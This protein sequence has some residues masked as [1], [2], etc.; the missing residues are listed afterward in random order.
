MNTTVAVPPA[1]LV[2]DQF[3]NPVSGHDV[4]FAVTAGGGTV[5]PATAIA[6]DGNGIARVTAWTLGTTAGMANNTLTATAAG[7]GLTGNPVTFTASAVADVAANIA[8]MAGDS[9][10]AVSETA[11]PTDPAVRVT[12]QFGNDVAGE[13]VTFQVTGGGGAV[14]GGTPTTN[15]SGVAAVGSWSVRATGPGDDLG[16]TGNTLEASI[17]AGASVTFTGFGVFSYETHVHPKWDQGC[18]GCHGGVAGLEL[19]PDAATSYAALVGVNPVCDTDGSLVPQGY[20][21]IATGGGTAARDLSI[22]WTFIAPPT[23]LVGDCDAQYMPNA[24]GMSTG[25]RDTIQAWI[26]NGAPDN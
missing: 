6:T 5:D 1:V 25:A 19:N 20:R 2:T 12:D 9:L 4:T 23:P 8:I 17:A 22:L 21:R 7:A 10:S 13:A 16:R 3:G 11:I 14:T 15:A 18:L 24:D 26:K